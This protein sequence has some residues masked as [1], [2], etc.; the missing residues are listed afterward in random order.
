MAIISLP[1]LTPSPLEIYVHS[2][3][4]LY[5]NQYVSKVSCALVCGVV[6][7]VGSDVPDSC[8]LRLPRLI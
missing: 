6:W 5:S 3:G 8:G 1:P 2:N 7:C 4:V